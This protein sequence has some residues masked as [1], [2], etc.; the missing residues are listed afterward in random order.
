MNKKVKALVLFSG[1][2]DSILAIKILKKQKIEVTALFLK[3]YFF[4]EKKAKK[5]AKR[6]KIPFISTDFSKE[7]LKTVMNPK[8]GYGSA[9][10]PCIDCHKLMIKKA[11]RIRKRGNFDFI[12]TGEVLGQRP[13]SQN[14][15]AINLIERQLG[16]K[17]KILR[18]LSAKL[19]EETLAEK[20]GLV[21]RESLLGIKGKSRKKQLELA[22]EFNLKEHPTP[23]GGCILTD[24]DFSE[25]L[26]ELFKIWKGAER[27]EKY[28]ENDIGLLKVGRHF[29]KNSAKIIVGRNEKE[30]KTIEKLSLK[31]DILIEMENYPGPLVLLRFYKG[32]KEK[33]V[34]EAKK[35]TQHYSTKSR[36]KK[37]VSFSI[38]E[39]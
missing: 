27:K 13:M 24:K 14:K 20:K 38:R 39:I 32:K 4:D 3:S 5:T 7:Q 25:R 16:M 9:L 8:H 33:L 18:P 12:A 15:R 19:L 1:G 34:K 6:I 35:I 26:K 23:A 30:N 2:L 10:N 31:K 22:K 37:D 17:G 36:F 21:Q 28:F 29:K 11:E